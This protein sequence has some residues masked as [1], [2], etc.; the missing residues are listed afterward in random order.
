MAKLVSSAETIGPGMWLSIHFKA[1]HAT[2]EE[3]KKEF[4][5]YMY[6]LSEEFPCGKCRTH[7]QEYLREHPFEPY[8]NMRD[9]KGNDLGMFKYAWQFHNTVNLRLH[10]PFVN[11]QT[12]ISMFNNDG[13]P[14][15][16]CT[17]K[18]GGTVGEKV[19]KNFNE[20]NKIVNGYF[21]KRNI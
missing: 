12:A 7:I 19:L 11:W 9:E 15:D 2:T 5:D 4:I 20:K 10:K 14:C 6:M 8:M 3:G 1:K 17:V 13:K 21:M 18:E 16:A